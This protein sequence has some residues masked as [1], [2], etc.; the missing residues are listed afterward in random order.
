[1]MHKKWFFM[2]ISVL[3]LIGLACNLSQSGGTVPPGGLQPTTEQKKP[4]SPKSPT[5]IPSSPIGIRQGLSSLNSYR[6]TTRTIINGPTAQDKS[7]ITTMIESGTDGKSSH[8]HYETISSSADNPDETNDTSDQYRVGNRTCDLSSTSEEATTSDVD[9]MQQEMMD[10]WY[11]MIDLVPMVNDPVFIGEEEIN[12][13]KTNHFKFTVSGLGDDSGAEVISSDG[14]YWLAQDGQ[15]I[16]KYSAVLET[17]SGPA[18]D[19]NTKTMH[20]EF[21]IE[22]Q[23]INQEII[24][25]LPSTCP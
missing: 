15:Y 22:V 1:M 20:T 23:D 12:G 9:P 17:R 21:Y 4:S 16:V 8:I 6:L 19:A 24:I 14:E 13:V 18:G 10:V 5:S 25:T 3:V 2:A 7:Q 11:N